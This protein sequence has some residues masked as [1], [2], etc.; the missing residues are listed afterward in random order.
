MSIQT[1]IWIPPSLCG[2][3][4]QITADFPD[5][6]VVNGVSY[7]HPKPFTITNIVIL[8]Q[9]STPSHVAAAK[10]MV[11]TS[12]FFDAPTATP[13]SVQAWLD[14][15]YPNVLPASV[16]NRGYLKYPIA[17]PTPAQC[18][19][20]FLSMHKGQKHSYPCG[21][22]AHEWIDDVGVLTHVKHPTNTAQCLCHQG[23]TVDMK[24][25]SADFTAYLA[26]QVTLPGG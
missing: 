17:N 9:C 22:S 3:Q 16:Q 4:L 12:R 18:L 15:K 5:G 7:R 13:G 1:A 19:Y 25:A 26:T 24:N 20:T 8:S 2:C 14:A 6:S 21:C 10:A 11:D 23:D